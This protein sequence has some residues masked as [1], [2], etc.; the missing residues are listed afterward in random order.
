MNASSRRIHLRDHSQIVNAVSRLLDVV[1]LIGTGFLAYYLKFSHL[2]MP[3]Q[4]LG[5]IYLS[6]L[7]AS[8]IFPYYNLYRG[9][10]GVNRLHEL[11]SN[12]AAWL[13]VFFCLIITAAVFGVS[14]QYSRAWFG[15]WLVM[16]LI[17]QLSFRFSMRSFLRRMRAQGFNLRSVV[18]LGSNGVGRHT[19][20]QLKADPELGFKLQGYFTIEDE[21]QDDS[22]P[23]S[24]NIDAGIEYIRQNRV[25]QVWIAM[26]FRRASQIESTIKS[27]DQCMSDIRLVPDIFGYRLLNHS[28]SSVGGLPMI[29]ISITPMD[30][31]NRWIKSCQD[32][33]LAMFILLLIS[34]LM[35]A[36][37]IGV[38]LSS[39]GPVFYRQERV[40]WNGRHFMMLKFRS[41]PV[42]AESSTGAVW[43]KAGESR[44]TPFGAFL[45]R[46]SLDELPQ[47]LNVLKGD[48]SIVGP[49]PERPVF[50]ER[51]KDEIPGYMQK[52]RVKAGITGWAQVNGWRGNTDLKK[53]IEYDLDYIE[54]WS[55]WFDLKII[56]LTLFKGFFHKN[57]Y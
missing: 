27:L 12:A 49:R 35:L 44:A 17:L 18:I 13:T 15:S 32:R 52:H 26:P 2:D 46:T 53:R 34:P 8:I 22:I 50:V 40:G 25:D 43:A 56:V 20:K 37:A 29:N 42:D 48:M 5:C 47:F 14:H 3:T 23:V 41:M 33:I 54:N 4:Y 11:R 6:V 10:R 7:Y 9:W 45:R 28:L 51:F 19:Y 31:V 24:G 39:P 16:G 36:L 30:G 38:K 55:L 1:I 57:A 21:D